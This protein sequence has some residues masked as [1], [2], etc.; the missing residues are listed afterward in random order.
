MHNTDVYIALGSNLGDREVNLRS[1]IDELQ[2]EVELLAGSRIYETAPYGYLDQADFLNQ[3]IKVRTDLLP[4]ELLTFMKNL[5]E[6]LGRIPT[7]RDGPRMIDLDILFYGDMILD[8]PDLVIPHPRLHERAFVLVP[9]ADIA[10]DLQHPILSY[11]I[12]ELLNKV[13]REGVA[14]FGA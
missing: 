1:A 4:Q 3:V 7:F 2:Q 13:G 8:L 14:L 5:E 9:L 11:S 12:L 6:E 10:P